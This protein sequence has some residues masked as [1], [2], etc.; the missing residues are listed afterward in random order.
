MLLV[1]D[2]LDD[3]GRYISFNTWEA[4]P[5]AGSEGLQ[6][7]TWSRVVEQWGAVQMQN[8]FADQTGRAI[9]PKDYAAWATYRSLGKAVT[10]TKSDDLEVLREYILSDEF[11]LAGLK[12]AR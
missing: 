8:R 4:R 11:E 10:R 5:V 12:A 9:L 7:V 2:E 6:P 1:A 3:F